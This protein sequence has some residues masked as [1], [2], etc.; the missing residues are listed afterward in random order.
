VTHAL[1]NDVGDPESNYTAYPDDGRATGLVKDR[2][3]LISAAFV[4]AYPQARSIVL[5]GT[6]IP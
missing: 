5:H 2:S 3:R 6:M 4:A 1:T